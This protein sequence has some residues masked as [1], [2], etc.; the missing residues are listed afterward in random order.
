IPPATFTNE[1]SQAS[2]VDRDDNTDWIHSIIDR[3][4][5]PSGRP[6]GGFQ[7]EP[8]PHEDI[9]ARSTDGKLYQ[10]TFDKFR[11]ETRGWNLVGFGGNYWEVGLASDPAAVSWAPG[12]IDVFVINVNNR[13]VQAYTND[14]VNW[15]W[16]DWGAPPPLPNG[17]YYFKAVDVASARPGRLD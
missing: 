17:T 12:R 10:F 4:P 13:L 8:L 5:N 1:L 9:F 11:T 15:N 14:G 16:G 3:P 6:D 2:P 7:G